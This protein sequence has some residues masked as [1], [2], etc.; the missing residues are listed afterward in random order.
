MQRKHKIELIIGVLLLL[1]LLALV[2]YLLQKDEPVVEVVEDAQE[3]V[4]DESADI[5]PEPEP[6]EEVVRTL[7]EDGPA[8]ASTIARGFVER[9]GSYST[10]GGYQNIEDVI[11]ISTA[12]LAE[13]LEDLAD[14]A[15]ASSDDEYY[16]IS[17]LIISVKTLEET[18]TTAVIE[19]LTQRVESIGSPRNSTTVYQTITINLLKIGDEWFVDDF[20]WE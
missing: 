12:S 4:L 8:G 9:F 17:T 1:A 11:A 3:D 20:L 6:E 5:T 16:G 14:S 7:P 2:Y 18:E 10:E 15:R 13:R 19:I